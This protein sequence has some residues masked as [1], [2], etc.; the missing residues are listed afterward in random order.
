MSR[1]AAR[2]RTQMR[3]VSGRQRRPLKAACDEAGIS[4]SAL[5][6][7]IG[8]SAGHLANVDAGIAR[9]SAE[10]AWRAGEY[11]GVSQDVLF[12]APVTGS[13]STGSKGRGPGLQTELGRRLASARRGRGWSRKELAARAGL[14]EGTVANTERGVNR[15]IYPDS[16][17]LLGRAL[18][19]GIEYFEPYV[20]GPNSA[21]ARPTTNREDAGEGAPPEGGGAGRARNALAR[22]MVGLRVEAGYSVGGLARAAG[23]HRN[24]ITA[25][26]SALQPYSRESALLLAAILGVDATEL[27][28]AGRGVVPA[29][30]E[31][32]AERA[33]EKGFERCGLAEKVLILRADAGISRCELARRAR[34]S[35]EALRKLEE[36]AGGVGPARGERGEIRRERGEAGGEPL[37]EA[38][39]GYGRASRVMFVR[40]LAGA[41]SV[42]PSELSADLSI[43]ELADRLIQLRA[44]WGGSLRELARRTG[45]HEQ[46]LMIAENGHKRSL[47]AANA[48]R[49]AN[50]YGAET[51]VV[52]R[53]GRPT[54]PPESGNRR[55][56]HRAEGPS[57]A[58]L[59]LYRARLDAALDAEELARSSGVDAR[60][61]RAAEADDPSGILALAGGDHAVVGAA[62][63][64]AAIVQ[65]RVLENALGLEPRT[66][67][68]EQGPPEEDCPC[69]GP[70][71]GSPG[72]REGSSPDGAVAGCAVCGA[73]GRSGEL[74][75]AAP[76]AVP[77]APAG[78][79]RPE[80]RLRAI[81]ADRGIG[82][83]AL[84]RSAGVSPK[85]VEGMAEGVRNLRT[86]TIFKLCRALGV[87]PASVDEG[88][89]RRV[90][91]LGER[92]LAYCA[93]EGVTLVELARRAGVPRD[94][95]RR[96]VGANGARGYSEADWR[97]ARLLD[98][99]V[100]S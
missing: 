92:A 98:S 72:L 52:Y 9:P 49:L 69:A 89:D 100:G 39:G 32:A 56:G 62:K 37:R 95:L 86:I 48:R 36:R 30:L 76:A 88:L 65:V 53:L 74:A 46:T 96:I 3:E 64:R 61:I 77:A 57:A 45:V 91:A 22:R 17:Y 10:L 1:L 4:R 43:G 29:E 99:Y 6:D 35:P 24:R 20:G 8:Y 87:S 41:L 73:G 21:L 42:E 5:A 58:A 83:A 18:E 84:A 33:R 55:G 2:S 44:A 47:G 54:E 19:M 59:A 94:S 16:A 81:Q 7:G 66:V 79:D 40:R 12:A 63:R 68:R 67:V 31:P 90:S 82:D 27:Q 78:T 13:P 28:P 38:V 14:S 15:V 75:A 70:A 93:R 34:S 80:Q 71:G 25:A 11:L 26:E 50:F 60:L 97:R 23:L 51:S 85:T